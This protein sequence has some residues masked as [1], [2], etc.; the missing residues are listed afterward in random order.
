MLRVLRRRDFALLWVAGLVSVTGDWILNAA[1]PYYVYAQTGST[2]ATAGMVVAELAPGVVAGTFAGVVVD[3]W[4]RKGLLVTS[5]LAQALTVCALLEGSLSLV[6]VVAAAQSLV[7]SFAVPAEGALLPTLI[8]DGEL[9][10]A[11]AL[12]ALN[13][14]LGRLLGAPLGAA[15][16]AAGGLHG[17]VI[18]DAVSFV[19][20]ASLVALVRAP[21]RRIA[22][23]APSSFLQEWREGLSLVRRDR[24]LQ[25]IFAVLGLMAFGGTM[26]D[27]LQVAWVRDSLGGGASIYAALL[28]VHAVFGI[29]GSLL[30]GHLGDR[31][32]PRVLMG[33]P[34]VIA[35]VS[36]LI[37]YDVPSIPLALALAA[38]SG[39]TSVVGSVGVE[40][41]VQRSVRDEQRGRVYGALGANAALLSL[42]GAALG[43]ALAERFGVVPMLNVASGLV[44]LSGVVVLRSLRGPGA[45]IR[46]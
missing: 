46:E 23:E 6:Y 15:F 3:R 31:F 20:A 35:G 39:V 30:V 40:T 36:L 1:L 25:L 10:A 28:W 22:I 5:N 45:T 43:G 19:G 17:V 41:L 27:P 8:A 14:R 11:N 37:R 24:T 34:S 18:A 33:W 44:L 12:N 13:N 4:S 38:V 16:L 32:S 2:V 21:V 7:A 9:V 29:G 26:L 42:A